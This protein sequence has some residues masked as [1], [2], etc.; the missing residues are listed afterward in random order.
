MYNNTYSGGNG[1]SGN[2]SNSNSNNYCSRGVACS[3]KDS[4]SNRKIDRA[5]HLLS[6]G[7]VRLGLAWLD[8]VTWRGVVRMASVRWLG[9]ACGVWC[10]V[11]EGVGYGWWLW[12]LV[13][14]LTVGWLPVTVKKQQ[15]TVFFGLGL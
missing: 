3:A 2:N 15:M 5:W 14:E 11:G 12:R 13:R 9:L 7:T 6:C 4:S 1:S 10:V 8:G